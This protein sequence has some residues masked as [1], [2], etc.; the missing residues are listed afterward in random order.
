[1]GTQPVAIVNEAMARLFWPGQSP[2]GKRFKLDTEKTWVT[3]VGEVRD[4]KFISLTQPVVPC[5]YVPLLQQ[6]NP[7][8]TL[9]LRTEG[10]SAQFMQTILAKVRGLEPRMP[11]DAITA[12]A[13]VDRALWVANTGATLLMTFGGLALFL[14]VVGTYGVISYSVRQRRGEIGLRMALGARR[15]DVVRL[16][17]VQGTTL[18]GIGILFGGLGALLLGI[19]VGG[20]LFNVR[21]ADPEILMYAASILALAA[22]LSSLLPARRAATLDPG[23]V[24]KGR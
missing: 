9:Y 6:H 7:Q 1:M 22:V 2:L 17:L 3:V 19:P 5:F 4:S 18:V 12:G 23:A 10:T 15:I 13:L 14:S 8:M 24:L 20:V 11:L 21:P 16:V